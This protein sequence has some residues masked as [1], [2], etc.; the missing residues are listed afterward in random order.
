[1]PQEVEWYLWLR[2]RQMVSWLCVLVKL[3]QTDSAIHKSIKNIE[4]PPWNHNESEMPK[5]SF[6]EN[7]ETN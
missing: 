2:F 5:S 7:A 6:L 1:M 3:Q 4:K